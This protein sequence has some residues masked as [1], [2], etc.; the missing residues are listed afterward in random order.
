M[1]NST[2]ILSGLFLLIIIATASISSAFAYQGDP[3]VKNPDYSIKRHKAI[4]K[5]FET[6]DF[7]AWKELMNNKGRVIQVINSDNFARFVEAHN[8]AL[9]GKFE[10]AKAIRAELGLGLR[11]GHGRDNNGKGLRRI[12]GNG[13][14]FN[15]NN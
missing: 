13:K 4:T 6:N 9:E 1:K 7:T 10:E 8:L 2:K 5:T 11:N 15:R 3:R 12:N 14:G